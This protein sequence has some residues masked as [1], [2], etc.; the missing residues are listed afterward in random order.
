[1]IAVDL[2]VDINWFYVNFCKQKAL[3][4]KYISLN[5]ILL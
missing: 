4:F 5:Y 1:M 3:T 2:Y